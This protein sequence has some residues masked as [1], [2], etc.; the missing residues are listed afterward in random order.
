MKKSVTIVQ[1]AGGAP[2]RLGR[3]GGVVENL[4]HSR[5]QSSDRTAHSELMEYKKYA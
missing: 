2:G 5:I 1:E 4:V 3:G